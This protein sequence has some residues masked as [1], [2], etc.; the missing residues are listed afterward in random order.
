MKKVLAL[1]SCIA[2]VAVISFSTNA[3]EPEKKATKAKTEKG[4]CSKKESK[5]CPSAC[6]K[7]AAEKKEETKEERK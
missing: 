2:F 5:K 3:Q 1:L 6:E 4:C 7:K